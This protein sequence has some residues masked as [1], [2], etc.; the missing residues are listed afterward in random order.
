MVITRAE[1]DP[2]MPA[3]ILAGG[4]ATRLRPL[5]D[6]IPKSLLEVAGHP[7][8]WH[9]L[10]LLKRNGIRHVILAVAYL[11]E[12]IYERFGNGAQLG[13]RLEYSFDGPVLLGTAGA[14]RKALPLLSE[15]FFV[16]YGDS[17]LTCDF[18]AVE[19]SFRQ[20]N[21]P[22]LMTV[23]RNN[24]QHDRSNVSF[25]GTR[26]LRYDKRGN[27]SDLQYIDYG[28]SAFHRSAFSDLPDGE[29]CDLAIVCNRLLHDGNMGAFEVHDRFYEIGSPA[30]LYD[31]ERF[32][33]TRE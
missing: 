25:D 5:T 10:Q 1:S 22:G 15:R 24:N 19:R 33:K 2:L 7:F 13:V 21:L 3:V 4:L 32:L 8:L 23:Y 16:L 27:Y 6:T 26:I 9:Q 18:S 14:I 12:K 29:S 31:T 28:L 17:Y 11:G 20:S 30:G